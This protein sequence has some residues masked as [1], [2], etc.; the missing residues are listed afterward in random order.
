MIKKETIKKKLDKLVEELSEQ[1][2][3]EDEFLEALNSEETLR[4]INKKDKDIEEEIKL[5]EKFEGA[6]RKREV[7]LY[8]ER[9][10]SKHP[11]DIDVMLKMIDYEY[12]FNKLEKY[13]ELKDKYLPEFMEENDLDETFSV[14]EDI[15]LYGIW[16]N[17]PFFRLLYLIADQESVK[18]D[19]EKAFEE[20]NF[21]LKLNPN[22]NQ[23]VRQ[24]LALLAYSLD[25]KDYFDSLYKKYDFDNTLK[26][27]RALFSFEKDRNYSKFTQRLMEINKYL[28]FLMCGELSLEPSEL[29]SLLDE[30]YAIGS[31][32]EGVMIIEKLF[33]YIGEE[34]LNHL[35]DIIST[36]EKTPNLLIY[37]L[38]NKITDL[39]LYLA[40]KTISE[41]GYA[42]E[43]TYRTIVNNIIKK[44]II[45]FY[46]MRNFDEKVLKD[47]LNLLVE[48][49][50]LTKIDNKTFFPTF[51]LKV[52]ADSLVDIF[53]SLRGSGIEDVQV[54]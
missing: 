11:D 14:P 7:K 22:D 52:I 35:R 4:R 44:P 25:K 46:E 6:H 34:K 39:I 19:L 48:D 31:L 18:G 37:T 20:F 16:E 8:G 17:R 2:T 3:N 23:G 1:Y 33:K 43:V 30:P 32:E 53:E 42:K 50:M 40:D 51:T 24:D 15:H 5:Y 27:G 29:A 10:L 28:C 26:F 47:K 41:E 49:G 36:F 12:P 9:I 21:I 38:D 54:A 13:H 45:D